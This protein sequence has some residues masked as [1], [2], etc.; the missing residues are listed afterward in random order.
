MVLSQARSQAHHDLLGQVAEVIR[1]VDLV[2]IYQMGEVQVRALDPARSEVLYRVD[3]AP[4]DAR[5]VEQ[6]FH[7]P[8]P[9][10]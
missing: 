3:G 8:E 2:R 5:D 6:V 7:Q 10:Q 9:V 4:R 1:I